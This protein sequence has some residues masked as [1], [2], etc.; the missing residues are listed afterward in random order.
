MVLAVPLLVLALAGVFLLGR[1]WRRARPGRERKR[2]GGF[3]TMHPAQRAWLR[4][5]RLTEPEHF[6]ALEAL[7]VSGHPGRQ[8]GRLELGEGARRTAVYLKREQG[9][10]FASRL[11]NFLSGFGWVSRSV[12]EAQVLE[13]LER[14]GLPGPRWLATGEDGAGRAFVLVAEAPGA[15]SLTRALQARRE[16]KEKRELFRRLGSTLARLHEAGFFHRD[17]YAK[18]VLVGEGGELCLLDWQ[19]AWRGAW[20]P[21]SARIRDLAC[22]HATLP[23]DLAGPRE[24][25]ACLR[26]YLGARGRRAA[27]RDILA[28]VEALARRLRRRRHIR[29]KRQLPTAQ[30]QALICLDGQAL[31]VTPALAE[32]TAAQ[33]LDW[34]ALENQPLPAGQARTRR[35]LTLAWGRVMLVRQRERIGLWKRW[36][37][38]LL[39]RPL[40][41]AGQRKA[42]LL[43]RLERHGAVAP[44]VLAFGQRRRGS[45]M[46]SFLLCETPAEAVRLSAWLR[47]DRPGGQREVVFA[48]AGELLARMHE[49][50]CYFSRREGPE[51]LAVLP[52]EAPRLLL[53]DADAV[54]ARRTP[55]PARARRDLARLRDFLTH[56]PGEPGPWASLERGYASLSEVRAAGPSRGGEGR[57][58][59]VGPRRAPEMERASW[60][61]R[62]V[63]GWRRFHQRPDWEVYAGPDWPD[64]IMQVGVTDDFHAKQGRSTGRWVMEAPGEARGAR[65]E[66]PVA[67][68]GSMG[69]RSAPPRQLPVLPPV[70]DAPGSPGTEF[71]PRANRLVVYL[72]RHY[73]LPFWRGWLAALWPGGDWSPA[74]QEYRHL[75]WAREQG[76]PAP[77]TVAAGE[78]GGAWGRLSSFLAV[79]ELTG[80]LPLHQAVPLAASRL[81]A[82]VFRKW[83]RG[84]AREMARVARLLHDRRHFHKDLY[85]CHFFI[86][87]DDTGGLPA[88]GE[89]WRGRVVLIDLHRLRHHRWT[90]PVWLLKDL[91]QLLYSSEVPGVDVRDQV[92]FWKFYRGPGRRNA[93][94]WLRRLVVLK[95]RRYRSHNLRRKQRGA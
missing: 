81:P 80:M 13:A 85:L 89:D 72:K 78:F 57:P 21:P 17:L 18:H 53:Q 76:I 79:E 58:G 32:R 56:P 4:E 64:R 3:V 90:W 46:D 22:L 20:I 87:R 8:V 12:R 29:E 74:M 75:E 62:L 63:W 82:E 55:C 42:T 11:V 9:V 5:L 51:A 94:R 37:A 77:A 27:R 59:P 60:W 95:W 1:W 65:A 10:R 25:L 61:R 43:W 52:G 15:V 35:W 2:G 88:G 93:S 14:D 38:L 16:A 6:L 24:R 92:A 7:L 68:E 33:P 26:G 48:Q 31:C 41:S 36:R 86:H 71:P 91:A 19:R 70:A 73:R 39:R 28:E 83:K 23:D 67:T 50:C 66:Q 44:R 54:E 34:L 45:A 47:M 40:I 69:L 84:L 30:Q 49:A